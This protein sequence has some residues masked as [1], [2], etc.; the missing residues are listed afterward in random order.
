MQ[1]HFLPYN[2][3]LFARLCSTLRGQHGPI[4]APLFTAVLMQG[5][6]ALSRCIRRSA[7]PD[8]GS[9]GEQ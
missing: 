9:S 2:R 1:F 7:N 4:M 5:L 3:P 6:F 8:G